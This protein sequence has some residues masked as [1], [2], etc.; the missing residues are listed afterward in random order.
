MRL[1]YV[2]GVISADYL[3]LLFA[4][5]AL[6]LRVGRDD[7]VALPVGPHVV[8]HLELTS[9]ALVQVRLG[10]LQVLLHDGSVS[11]L[12]ELTPFLDA[13]VSK[14]A[15]AIHAHIARRLVR[16]GLARHLELFQRR[17]REFFFNFFLEVH[18]LELNLRIDVPPSLQRTA[19]QSNDVALGGALLSAHVLLAI[20]DALAD[21]VHVV[22]L[23]EAMLSVATVLIGI[24]L[25][26]LHLLR[27][28]LT[29]CVSTSLR[30]AANFGGCQFRRLV[31]TG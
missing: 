18:E 16:L 24:H 5:H 28:L 22:G 19:R 12:S 25:S 9:T 10:L 11:A 8:E 17:F 20:S 2:H 23:G 7:R 21:R 27:P 3:L 14:Y 1:C 13:T 4:D 26:L 29:S 31:T 15:L 30:A 6:A